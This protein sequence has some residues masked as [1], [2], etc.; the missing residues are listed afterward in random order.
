MSKRAGTA[1]G[2]PPNAPLPPPEGAAQVA[3]EVATEVATDVGTDAGYSPPRFAP[4]RESVPAARSRVLDVLISAFVILNLITVLRSNRPSWA[5]RAVESA[6]GDSLGPYALYRLNYTGWLVDRYAHLTGLNNRWEMF[7]HQSRFNW[8]YGIQAVGPGGIGHD[9]DLPGIGQRSFAQRWL[10]DFREAKYH[11]NLYGNEDLRQRYAR[12]LCRNRREP[13]GA[14]IVGVGF[15]LHHQDLLYPE[16]ARARGTHLEPDIHTQL[17]NEFSCGTGASL[18][19]VVEPA[20]K[21]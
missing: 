14:E 21:E 16:E 8:W 2:G 6:V 3:T 5:A 7:S 1:A 4:V 10:F 17:L 20:S 12:Y 13:G 11:L 18:P 15:L 19:P 9:L